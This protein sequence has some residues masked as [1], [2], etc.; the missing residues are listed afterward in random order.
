MT[1]RRH[2]RLS[3]AEAERELRSGGGDRARRRARPGLVPAALRGL[4]PDAGAICERLDLGLA[5]WTAWGQ[6]WEESTPARIAALVLR[7]LD[8]GA[9]VLL[10][11]SAR[12]AERERAPATAEAIA[13]IAAA[14]RDAGCTW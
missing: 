5:Y 1:H 8:P 6:D 4:L 2:D 3:A 7:D 9:I 11:D 12:Y 13:P 10:H 14:A